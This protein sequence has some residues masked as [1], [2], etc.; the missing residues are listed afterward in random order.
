MVGWMGAML[1]ISKTKQLCNFYVDA[2]SA[3]ITGGAMINAFYW[4]QKK[5]AD[6]YVMLALIEAVFNG[7]HRNDWTSR[8]WRKKNQ[9]KKKPLMAQSWVPPPRTVSVL[10]TGDRLPCWSRHCCF[11]YWPLLWMAA[12]PLPCCYP[13]C[14]GRSSET[15]VVLGCKRGEKK[16]KRR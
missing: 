7:G 4:A 8:N 14:L 9:K 15:P 16:T 5:K 2:Y 12:Y 13:D 10:S 11:L 1:R 6:R 3:S